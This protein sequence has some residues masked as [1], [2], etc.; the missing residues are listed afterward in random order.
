MI[1][2]IPCSLEYVSS[3][4]HTELVKDFDTSHAQLLYSNIQ[5]NDCV[6]SCAVG[7]RASSQAGARLRLERGRTPAMR[8]WKDGG[9]PARP[10]RRSSQS[11]PRRSK[12]LSPESTLFEALAV[13]LFA[14]RPSSQ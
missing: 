5:N 12:T 10:L 9:G 4:K 14:K 2:H 13:L 11:T 8:S 7:K 3:Y 1:A 6:L